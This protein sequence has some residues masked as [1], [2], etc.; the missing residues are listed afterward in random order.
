MDATLRV[1]AKWEVDW[2]AQWQGEVSDP[3]L[4]GVSYE[5]PRKKKLVRLLAYRIGI[6][7]HTIGRLQTS[8]Q[9]RQEAWTSLGESGFLVSFFLFMAAPVAYGSSRAR[10]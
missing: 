6:W 2:K 8:R 9:Q 4:P 7:Q 1:R 5:R 10:V 3:A